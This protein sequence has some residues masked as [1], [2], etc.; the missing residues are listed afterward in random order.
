LSSTEVVYYKN[1]CLTV[2]FIATDRMMGCQ[3]SKL[4]KIMA[5]FR[6]YGNHPI[7][8]TG[9]YKYYYLPSSKLDLHLTVQTMAL[10]MATYFDLSGHPHNIKFLVQKCKRVPGTLVHWLV[11]FD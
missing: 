8:N 3:T 2:I 6:F 1:L 9:Q 5:P 7:V 4:Y 10:N 11:S